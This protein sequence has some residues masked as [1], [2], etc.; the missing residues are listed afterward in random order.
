MSA[1][2]IFNN[3]NQQHPE[4][5]IEIDESAEEED[6][7]ADKALDKEDADKDYDSGSFNSSF[8]T[9]ANFK[10]KLSFEEVS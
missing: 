4:Y 5:R 8:H 1:H 6:A 9:P 10:D 7:D 3:S 2:N